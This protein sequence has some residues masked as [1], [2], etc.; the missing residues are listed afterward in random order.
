MEAGARGLARLAVPT[1]GRVAL[2]RL[3][4]RNPGRRIPVA[5]RAQAVTACRRSE[6]SHRVLGP[7]TLRERWTRNVGGGYGSNRRD[8]ESCL[9]AVV[10]AAKS[11]EDSR[12][13]IAT[14]FEDGRAMAAREG[15]D[16]I[17]TSRPAPGAAIAVPD[18]RLRSTTLSAWRLV[19]LSSST[20]TASHVAMAGR[21]ATSS[22]STSGRSRP[23]WRSGPRRTTPLTPF[24]HS[25]WASEMRRTRAANR[26]QSRQECVDSPRRAGSMAGPGRSDCSQL[27]GDCGR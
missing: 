24:S 25:R 15:W 12:G 1:S 17:R 5:E 10:Y 22:S 4:R 27:T 16:V 11:T 20:R 3:P 19:C 9:R 7:R 18:S 21:H 14:Q 26:L 2:R 23:V 13:S 6:R 8:E